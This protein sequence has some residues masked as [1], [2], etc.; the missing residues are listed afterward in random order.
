M[1]VLAPLRVARSTWPEEAR[2]WQHLAGMNV[3]PIVG[4]EAERRAAL[5]FDAQVYATNYEQLPWL[6]EHWGERWP[7]PR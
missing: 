7:Y 1:L 3:M 2:K 4:T 6:V 5:R